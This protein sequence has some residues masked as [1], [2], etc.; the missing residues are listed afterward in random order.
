LTVDAREFRRVQRYGWDVGSD[1]YDRS[2][3]PQLAW[4]TRRCVERAQPRAGERV[5][6]LATGTGVGALAAAVAVGPSGSVTGIDVSERMV[7]LAA[8]RASD[9]RNVH[10]ERAD[11]EATGGADG[12]YHAVVCA[13]G[14]MFAADSVAAFAELARVTAPGG[15]VSV[16]VWGRR[17][18]CG[19]AD[20]FPIV[21]S[22][23]EGD[24]CPLSFLL[25]APGALT[26]ALRRAG[27][28]VTAEERVS[29]TLAW[30]SA[31]DACDAL[32]EG[33][34][35]ALAWK[36]FSPEVRAEVRVAFLATLE[37][38]RRGQRYEVP[39]EVLFATARKR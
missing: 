13:F 39:A 7:A 6:D 31:D 37:P 34:A 9:A 35:V 3:V 32:L 16:C 33:G 1:A 25:G 5:L 14:L 18:A 38:F 36:N 20:V 12:G 10:F 23:S 8:A 27:L 4:L 17:S 29:V 21:E 22:R 11:M 24:A 28:E 2:W 15:R 26:F 19:F 30:Q